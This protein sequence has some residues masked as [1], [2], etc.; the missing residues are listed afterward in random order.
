MTCGFSPT[1]WDIKS[2]K[3]GGFFRGKSGVGGSVNWGEPPTVTHVGS[4]FID[5]QV[6]IFTAIS[7][8]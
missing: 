5:V 6:Q 2:E 3:V 8:Q 7:D 4:L 1:R